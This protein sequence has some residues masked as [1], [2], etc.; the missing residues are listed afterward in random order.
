MLVYIFVL[1]IIM[2]K[3]RNCKEGKSYVFFSECYLFGDLKVININF[4]LII[5]DIIFFLMSY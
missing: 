5:I 2:R 4:C 3:N 1:K